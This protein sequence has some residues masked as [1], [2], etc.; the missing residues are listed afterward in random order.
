MF[1]N[2]FKNKLDSRP[3]LWILLAVVVVLSDMALVH[4]VDAF[5]WQ[6]LV[7]PL[8]SASFFS[9]YAAPG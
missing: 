6:R 5:A 8:M 9:E 1:L 2:A 3:A 7:M 4:F